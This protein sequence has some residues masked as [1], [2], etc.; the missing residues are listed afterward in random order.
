[1]HQIRYRKNWYLRRAT[2]SW[3]DKA[4]IR[5]IEEEAERL[6]NQMGIH[7]EVVHEIPI[8]G[9]TVCGLHVEHN[10]KV[11]SQSWKNLRRFSTKRATEEQ[12]KWLVERGFSSTE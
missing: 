8:R 9:R 6:S 1:M 3:A 2:P 5:R 11:V 12:M 4:A 7:M 10:L